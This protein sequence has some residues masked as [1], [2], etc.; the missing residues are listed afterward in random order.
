MDSEEGIHQKYDQLLFDAMDEEFSE[1]EEKK[2][3]PK[4]GRENRD[5][6]KEG[7]RVAPNEHQTSRWDRFQSKCDFASSCLVPFPW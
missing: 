1:S 3:Q 2:L 7:P 4:P 5:V 6:L